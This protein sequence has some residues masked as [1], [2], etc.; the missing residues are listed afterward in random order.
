MPY[1]VSVL[2]MPAKFSAAS[3]SSVGIS[4]GQQATPWARPWVSDGARNPPLRPDAPSP[5]RPASSTTTSRDGSASLARI[6]V[7]RPVK[8][9]PTTSRSVRG[10]APVSLGR[11]SGRSGR[12][13]QNGTG[14][15]SAS[16]AAARAESVETGMTRRI[17][18]CLGGPVNPSSFQS[19][20]PAVG[21]DDL[22]RV[23]H[24]E[25]RAPIRVGTPD[26]PIEVDGLVRREYELHGGRWN[27]I[28]S[29]D[30]LG[31][32]PDE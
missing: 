13:V 18:P 29:P 1:A 10:A 6:A 15:A 3:R 7:H 32:D 11:G 21:V 19:D 16:A 4:S 28:E 14:R 9:P 25:T 17:R 20:A 12:S 23:F 31:H 8:P 27:M 30:G 24:D 2:W 22:L 5:S 26:R